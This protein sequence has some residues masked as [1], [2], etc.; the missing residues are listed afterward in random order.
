MRKNRTKTVDCF[1]KMDM[2]VCNETVMASAPSD[3]Y[4]PKTTVADICFSFGF[5]T[6][7]I[8]LGSSP[9]K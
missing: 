1:V 4:C 7:S 8:Q 6:E 3:S 5:D 2:H 9:A